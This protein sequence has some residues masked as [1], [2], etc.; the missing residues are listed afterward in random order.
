MRPYPD[1]DQLTTNVNASNVGFQG[2]RRLSA[3][4]NS[5]T[6]GCHTVTNYGT[7]G[8]HAIT[9]S[10]T[11]GTHDTKN[12]NDGAN[13]LYGQE[14]G[15]FCG[16]HISVGAQSDGA[17]GGEIASA[18]AQSYGT[19]EYH[20]SVSDT[21]EK[22]P[23]VARRDPVRRENHAQ[24]DATDF[25]TGSMGS[26]DHFSEAIPI[27][28]DVPGNIH[29]GLLTPSLASLGIGHERA[30]H[31]LHDTSVFPETRTTSSGDH[32]SAINPQQKNQQLVDDRGIGSLSDNQPKYFN[33]SSGCSNYV[34][35]DS[36]G[37]LS[38]SNICD[39]NC[40]QDGRD[41]IIPLS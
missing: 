24:N 22:A 26:R 18:D 11:V 35:D 6:V 14:G 17:S 31:L 23:D 38:L 15:A 12:D 34:G 29:T 20:I 40:E 9:N 41:Q 21:I 16:D 33:I 10:E 1:A 8:R 4:S 27:Q 32:F 36:S 25:A 13:F 7:A 37:I 30:G 2:N 5:G 39:H 3:G 19:F 28:N